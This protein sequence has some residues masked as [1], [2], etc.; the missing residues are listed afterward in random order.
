MTPRASEFLTRHPIIDGHNDLAWAMKELC[1]YD[2]D[3]YPLDTEQSKPTPTCQDSE[4][5]E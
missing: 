1:D 3:A 5:A 4:Q 2:L